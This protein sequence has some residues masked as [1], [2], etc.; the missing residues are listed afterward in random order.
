MENK[1]VL[2]YYNYDKRIISLRKTLFDLLFLYTFL[3]RNVIIF[4]K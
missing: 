3:K 1:L 2:F 4:D